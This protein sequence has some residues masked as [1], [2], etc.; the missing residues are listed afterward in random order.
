MKVMIFY[1]YDMEIRKYGDS[2][3][4][5]NNKAIHTFCTQSSF[6]LNIFSVFALV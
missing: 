1:M 3:S 6:S 5:K 4:D 2:A